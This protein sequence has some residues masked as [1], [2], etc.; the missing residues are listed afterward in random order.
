MLSRASIGVSQLGH[1][2]LGATTEPPAGTRWT[3][4]VRKLPM[5]SP[6]GMASTTRIQVMTREPSVATRAPGP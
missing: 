4:T 1:R 6:K 5:A 3:T 2:L